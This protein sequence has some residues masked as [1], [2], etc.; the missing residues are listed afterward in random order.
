MS[1]NVNDHAALLNLGEWLAETVNGCYMAQDLARAHGKR[2][3]EVAEAF[4]QVCIERDEARREICQR[5]IENPEW[6][7]DFAH[8]RGW[9][10]FSSEAPDPRG[11]DGIRRKR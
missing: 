3:L 11:W 4:R 1:S 7:R 2:L 5:A 10:C 8:G 6:Q 9:N